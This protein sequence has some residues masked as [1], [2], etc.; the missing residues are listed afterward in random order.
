MAKGKDRPPLWFAH[1]PGPPT[2]KQFERWWL[3]LTPEWRNAAVAEIA[4]GQPVY[5]GPVVCQ[6]YTDAED[7][8][9]QY[10]YNPVPDYCGGWEPMGDLLAA[11]AGWTADEQ[12]R[13]KLH[14]AALAEQA[15]IAWPDALWAQNESVPRMVAISAVKAKMGVVA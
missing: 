2:L 9:P 10:E 4:L 1:R 7:G 13:M 15:G 12:A 5:P 3:S 11:V 6:P 14:L 8:E